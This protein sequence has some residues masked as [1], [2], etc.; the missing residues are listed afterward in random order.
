MSKWAQCENLIYAAE[1]LQCR[2]NDKRY[3]I[4]NWAQYCKDM[5][6]NFKRLIKADT[7]TANW[8]FLKLMK[9]IHN[10]TVKK[11]KTKECLIQRPITMYF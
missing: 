4:I 8:T 3:W 11:H 5:P 9:N 7:F 10:S 2:R 1:V 6:S